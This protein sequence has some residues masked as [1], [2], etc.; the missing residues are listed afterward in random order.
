M[1]RQRH[2][3]RQARPPSGLTPELAAE[4]ASYANQFEV[5]FNAFEFLFDFAQDYADG[6]SGAATHTR[7]VTAPAYAKVFLDLLDRS[8]GNYEAQFG[9]ITT[10]ART[11]LVEGN[12]ATDDAGGQTR[13]GQ[14]VRRTPRSGSP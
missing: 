6:N 2:P 11:P 13:S 1:R 5:G 10:P 14:H 7:I 4:L 8:I 12:A 3:R 9:A